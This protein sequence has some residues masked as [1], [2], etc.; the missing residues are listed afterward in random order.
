VFVVAFADV[1][2]LPS[3]GFATLEA[4][5]RDPRRDGPSR[6]HLVLSVFRPR[7]GHGKAKPEDDRVSYISES[8][9]FL[10]AGGT[11][12]RPA[13]KGKRTN[14]TVITSPPSRNPPVTGTNDILIG[15]DQKITMNSVSR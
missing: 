12:C 1:V 6:F 14:S 15:H 9:I 5:W 8:E 7:S 10:R 13:T 11:E 4:A 3:R 2:C